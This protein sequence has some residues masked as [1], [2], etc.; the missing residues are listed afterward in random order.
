MRLLTFNSHQPYLYA[1]ATALPWHVGVVIPRAPSG[2]DKPWDEGVRP[3]PSNVRVFPSLPAAL[4]VG[5]WDCALAH[6][7]HDLLEFK[8]VPI[9]KVFLVHG[10]ITG[11]ILQDGSSLDARAYAEQVQTLLQA[12]GCTT[13]Y[14]S[15][16]KRDDWGLPG[17]VIETAFDYGAYGGHTG[18]VAGVLQVSNHLR[19]R[20]AILGWDAH[21]TVCDGL[22]SLV[23]GRNPGLEGA[24]PAEDWDDLRLQYR[25]YRVYL[26]TAVHPYEDGFNLALMEAMATGM[27]IATVAHPTS[28]ITDGVEGVVSDD[29][30]ALRKKVLALLADPEAGRVMGQ[31]ARRRVQTRFP[32]DRFRG[33]WTTLADDLGVPP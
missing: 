23:L 12:L 22:E 10:T 6:N 11:R 14:I 2:A 16:L 24:R 15:A 8:D 5:A 30:R 13:V 1:L 17:R 19:E 33:A 32:L 27:P 25:R 3:L 9:P 29:A 28:P 4:G 20:G 7:V 26:H 31:A 21:A 18:E